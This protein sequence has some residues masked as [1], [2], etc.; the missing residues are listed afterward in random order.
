M[1]R[2][3]LPPFKAT[4]ISIKPSIER[5]R[6]PR[7]I[8]KTIQKQ[9]RPSNLRSAKTKLVIPGYEFVGAGLRPAPTAQFARSNLTA[10][11]P[12]ANYSALQT[13]F[14]SV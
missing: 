11:L 13:D 4:S 12:S 6:I 2:T 7:A 8:T 3:R 10:T 5:G 9:K 1:F 14:T